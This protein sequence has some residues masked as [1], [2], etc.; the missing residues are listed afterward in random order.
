MR[1]NLDPFNQ[2]PDQNKDKDLL[3][4]LLD[5][6]G[7]DAASAE[8]TMLTLDT[9]V[10]SRGA[11]LSAGQR[12]VIALARAIVRGSKLLFM[13]EATSSIGT[14]PSTSSDQRCADT[15][16]GNRLQHRRDD[17]EGSP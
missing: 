5:A 1:E 11:N 2:H 9:Q 6:Q 8:R 4:A 7:L 16:K 3:R 10:A 13:D 15:D 17:P 12:Q 14:F